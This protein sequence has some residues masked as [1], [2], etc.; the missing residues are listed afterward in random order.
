MIGATKTR[1][2]LAR[3]AAMDTG[4]PLMLSHDIVVIGGSTG[5]LPVL[6][7]LCAGLPA[8]LPASVSIVVH[9]G[10]HGQNLLADV[11]DDCGPLRVTTAEEGEPI[12][13][14]RVYVAP[15][16]H[17]LLLDDGVIRLGRGPRENMTRP[18][19]DPLFR[20]A[21]A[22]YGPRVIGVVL[23]GQL[24][25]GSAGLAAV[26]QCGGLA[27]VQSPSEAEANGMPS[28]ALQCCD[29]D[30]EASSSEL[31]ALLARLV[32]QPAGPAVS[33]PPGIAM[34]AEFALG[35]TS[36][37]PRLQQIADPST[38]SCPACG[39]VL[40]EMHDRH[41]LRFRCQIGHAY[42]AE[43]LDQEQDGSAHEGLGIALRML[44]SRATLVERMAQEA[45]AKGRDRIAAEYE[46]R[47][48]EYRRNVEA[49]WQVM[50]RSDLT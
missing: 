4:A 49:I 36:D 38:I 23:S 45:R 11:L 2:A 47:A 10:R 39:G 1:P 16:D 40:S 7:Q 9:V 37:S 5:S 25:D 8:D 46:E 15:G 13:R 44:E 26:K 31:G 28:S 24:N 34:E 21:A 29:V 19:V 43:C 12:E 30:Y 14:G 32:Q 50:L 33:I 6:K 48:V 20:S 35:R 42:T 22:G 18:A 27:V 3:Y 17:H 41:T